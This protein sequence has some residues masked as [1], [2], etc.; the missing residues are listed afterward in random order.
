VII[1]KI[2]KPFSVKAGKKLLPTDEAVM[3][4]E[5]ILPSIVIYNS[6]SLRLGYYIIVER[7]T[8]IIII[9]T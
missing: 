8:R 4:I 6:R 9:L 1:K 3:T 5:I 7:I 2:L